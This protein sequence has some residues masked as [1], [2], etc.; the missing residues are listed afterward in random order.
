MTG[1]WTECTQIGDATLYLGDCLDVLPAIGKVDSVIMDPPYGNGTDYGESYTDTEE[2]LVNVI[3]FVMP[4]AIENS[5][6]CMI[7]CG[8]SNQYFYPRPKWTLAWVIPAGTGRGPWGFSCW[9]PVLAYG[10]CPYLSSGKG[11]RP[12]IIQHMETS[13][14]NGHPC[15]KPILFMKKLVER[16]SLPR[17]LILDPIMGSG[18]TGVA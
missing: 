5:K 12:D 17:D 15:P 11:C 13:E 10:S 18:T 8:N 9:Q 4:W 3:S 1:P 6:R 16:A 14:K 7:T 2:E